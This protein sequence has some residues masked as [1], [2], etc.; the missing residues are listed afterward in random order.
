MQTKWV[1]AISWVVVQLCFNIG[2][3][4]ELQQER[5]ISRDLVVFYDDL[6]TNVKSQ[7]ELIL[8][9][10]MAIQDR[11]EI[12]EQA[13][14]LRAGQC[15]DSIVSMIHDTWQESDK[16]LT[17]PQALRWVWVESGCNPSAKSSKG[18][19]GLTQI[20]P[21]T[22][23][24][25]GYDP[26]SLSNPKI[27]LRASW[28]ILSQIAK[29]HGGDVSYALRIWNWGQTRTRNGITTGEYSRKVLTGLNY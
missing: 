11:L 9:G 25:Y 20:Q 22:A 16:I 26:R 8:S 19:Y 2:L 6:K 1:I 13:R 7:Q 29:E 15:P 18:A 24:H 27:A 5:Q 10:V 17:L 12:I 28:S 21:E 23:R 3:L 4:V 14:I